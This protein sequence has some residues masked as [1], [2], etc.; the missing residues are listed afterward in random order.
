MTTLKLFWGIKFVCKALTLFASPGL[1]SRTVVLDD[2]VPLSRVRSLRLLMTG[3]GPGFSPE[4]T[5]S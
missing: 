5:F 1:P 3:F 4:V 2:C